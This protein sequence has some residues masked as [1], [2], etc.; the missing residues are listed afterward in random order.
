[1]K[2]RDLRSHDTP[3]PAPRRGFALPMVI[4][5]IAVVTAAL[6]ASLAA[7]T[8]EAGTT[9]AQR[10]QGRAFTI[11]QSAL[12]LF[13]LSRDSLCAAKKS[14]EICIPDLGKDIGAQS[15]RA[16]SL[17]VAIAGGYAELVAHQVRPELHDT[18]PAM[19]FVRAR[20]VDTVS[21]ISGRDTL[22]SQRTVGVM[23]QYNTNVMNVLSA[24]TSLSGIMK[25]GTAGIVSG[26]DGCGKKPT[27]AG[28]AVPSGEFVKSGNWTAIGT[29]PADSAS[30]L[31]ELKSRVKIDWNA[32]INLNA[33]PADIEIPPQSFPTSSW[34]AADTSRWPVIRIHTNGFSLPNNGRGI[35]IADGDFTI[36]GS[37][38]WEGIILVGGKLSSNGTN[39]TSGATLSGLNLLLPNSPPPQPGYVD[40]N[41]TLGGQKDYEYNSC[42]ISRAAQRMK[43]FKVISNAWLDDVPTW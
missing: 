33:I 40:D 32:I 31:T 25:N 4:L 36:S 28:F 6:T 5:I 3:R 21:R 1:M 26:V 37:N 29:P 10:G 11:A 14:G 20:G 2:P 8:S 43:K 35:I 38:M 15:I 23:A 27:V 42:F 12:D 39:T 9:T 16:D 7:A 22:R 34:F 30:S 17:R 13:M 41:A 19:Y 24:W 18:L